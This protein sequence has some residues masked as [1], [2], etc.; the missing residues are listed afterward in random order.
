MHALLH[1]SFQIQGLVYATMAFLALL[2]HNCRVS[3]ADTKLNYLMYII[4][5]RGKL[6]VGDIIG[7]VYCLLSTL[8]CKMQWKYAQHINKPL[9]IICIY[10]IYI[11]QYMLRNRGCLLICIEE[12]NRKIVFTRVS[13]HDI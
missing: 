5:F 4:F 13:F 9:Y 2:A 11:G 8:C 10:I 6:I 3:M 7:I 1:I 12:Y